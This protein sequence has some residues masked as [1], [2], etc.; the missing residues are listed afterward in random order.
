MGESCALS[1]KTTHF[2]L[3]S[4]TLAASIPKLHGSP[5]TSRRVAMSWPH[6][7]AGVAEVAYYSGSELC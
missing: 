5:F 2:H 6:G 1:F 3:A 4:L 7:P